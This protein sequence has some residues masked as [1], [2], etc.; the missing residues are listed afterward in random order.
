MEVKNMRRKV[1]MSF[2][3]LIFSICLFVVTT[4]AYFLDQFTDTFNAEM[5]EVD[6][7][8]YAYFDDGGSGYSAQEVVIN[9][10]NSERRLT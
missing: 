9:S 5:G 1:S 8:L 2:V 6:V 7:D 3:V 10:S 4:Y